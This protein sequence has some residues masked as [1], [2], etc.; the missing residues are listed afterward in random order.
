MV[1]YHIYC[2]L[3]QIQQQGPARQGSGVHQNHSD[4]KYRRGKILHEKNAVY[5]T[6]T[7]LDWD[8]T[9]LHSEQVEEGHD[10]V[11]PATNP[12]REGYT[13]IGW[14]KPITNIIADLTVIAQYK[15]GTALN[16][17]EADATPQPRKVMIEN[18][19]YILMPDGTIY[20]TWGR[21]MA[22]P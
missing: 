7:F 14:S 22:I 8:A 13:F 5:F 4:R 6:V 16:E 1:L 11:G 21:K 17:T 15:E 12:V 18:K 20:D 19:L 2:M 9:L 3:Q 10:A